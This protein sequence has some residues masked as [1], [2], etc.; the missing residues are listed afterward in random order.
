M[1]SITLVIK[2]YD[3][4]PEQRRLEEVIRREAIAHG[5]QDFARDEDS[6]A[7]A[8]L[9]FARDDDLPRGYGQGNAD[10][11]TDMLELMAYGFVSMGAM[12][13]FMRN[14]AGTVKDWLDLTK[15]SRQTME[16]RIGDEKIV[17]KAGDDLEEIVRRYHP[18]DGNSNP[19]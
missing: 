15:N 19:L 9:Q 7:R 14:V 8:Y 4:T 11:F 3:Y 5:A 18:D 13:V 12:A 2:T 16:V 17:L 6:L 10:P 1:Q